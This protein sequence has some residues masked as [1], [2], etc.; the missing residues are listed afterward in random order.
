MLCSRVTVVNVG[1]V[2]VRVED[3][4]KRNKYKL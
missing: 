4:P 1:I 2:G 3:D